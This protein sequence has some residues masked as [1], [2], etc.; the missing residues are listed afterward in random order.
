MNYC[1]NCIY[2]RNAYGY[3]VKTGFSMPIDSTCNKFLSN[4]LNK[5][6]TDTN[7]R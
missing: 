6:W 7:S 1:I 3:C 5:S 4:G 2:Y